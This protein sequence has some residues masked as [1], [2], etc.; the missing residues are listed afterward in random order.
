[1]PSLACYNAREGLDCLAF[2][3]LGASKPKP[4]KL[5]AKMRSFGVYLTKVLALKRVH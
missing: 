2:S 4:K 3:G 5:K 1:M